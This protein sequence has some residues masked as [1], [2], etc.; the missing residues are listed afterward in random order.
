MKN[1][2]NITHTQI[3]ITGLMTGESIEQKMRRITE[4]KEPIDAISPMI[5]TERKDGVVAAYDIR[6]D[7]FE[8]AQ[9]AMDKIHK[10]AFAKRAN[11]EKPIETEPKVEPGTTEKTE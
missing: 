8:I 6:T 9:E 2:V 5:Y 10:S 1:Q 7:R 3:K 11:Q 4:T